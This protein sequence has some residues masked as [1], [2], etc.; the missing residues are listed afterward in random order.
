MLAVT[1]VLLAVVVGAQAVAFSGAPRGS[2]SPGE[3]LGKTG[4]AYLGGLRTF[5]AA[6]IWNRIDPQGHTYFEG[7][8]L[9]DQTFLVPKMRMVTLLDP[10]FTDAYYVTSWI[11]YNRMGPEDGVAVAREG[12]VANPDSGIIRAN[13]VQLLF[14]Q[15]KTGNRPEILRHAKS[16]A[17]GGLVWKDDEEQFEGY[18][19][20]MH[21][22]EDSGELALAHE[23]QS[24]LDE[25]RSGGVGLGDHD[26]DGD[27]K[28]DH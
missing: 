13:L 24:L 14:L 23:I 7:V 5:A 18:A 11:V 4:F 16:I 9:T 25:W 21:A 10:T 17:A 1:A 3:L 26:H 27:G 6:V 15:D 28:Q 12:L 2:T 8:G 22:L 20:A 19:I